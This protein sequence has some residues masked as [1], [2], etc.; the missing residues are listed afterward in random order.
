MNPLLLS[1]FG[2]SIDVN[3]A[4]LTVKQKD[5]TIEFEPHRIHHETVY[6][7]IIHSLNFPVYC[8]HI[9]IIAFE[10]DFDLM[11]EY[12]EYSLEPNINDNKSKI[13]KYTSIPDEIKDHLK[14]QYRD[15]LFN[16]DGDDRQ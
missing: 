4:H 11:R 16:R 5:S 3:K 9:N 13:G 1:G 12:I 2:I 10:I 15:I 7:I 14:N 8:G 6:V